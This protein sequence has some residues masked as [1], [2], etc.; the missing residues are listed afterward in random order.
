MVFELI[1]HRLHCHGVPFL[2]IIT[3]KGTI[4]GSRPLQIKR[5]QGS[6]GNGVPGANVLAAF[7]TT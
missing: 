5:G 6:P 7:E 3:G 2:T 1:L 4:D